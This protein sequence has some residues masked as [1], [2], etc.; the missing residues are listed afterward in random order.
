MLLEYIIAL[1]SILDR[2]EASGAAVVEY[3][4]S[5]VQEDSACEIITYP[6]QGEGST[7]MVKI[8]IPG[9]KGKSLGKSA[10]TIGLL[11]RLGGLGARPEV[12]GFV[13]D[14]DGALTVL[15]VA[16]KLLDMRR[17][18]DCLEGD[19][20]IST[21]I[22]PN[23]P[24][25]EHYPVHFMGSPVDMAQVNR[26]EVRSD[27]DA[28]LCVDTTKGN[29]IVN[30]KGFAITPTVKDGYILRVSESLLDL[31]EWTTGLPANV[32]PITTQDITPY[33]NG[34]YHVNSILQ[35]ATAT[36]APVV[37][38]A[39]TTQTVVPGC[40]PGASHA[41]DIETT[42]RFM[43]EAA[44]AFGQGNCPIYDPEEFSHLLRLYGSM[45]HLKTFGRQ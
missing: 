12:T 3:L 38:V 30:H 5:F 33:G 4:S 2:P 21:H 26:E 28:V 9:T 42:A 1:F 29:R 41:V 32:L 23:A 14:G 31:V 37:G 43:L 27:L 40:A 7:D 20:F 10:P 8:H 11:G 13:S 24:T 6:L 39:I 15:A 44:K 45:E 17:C 22:C 16:A 34:V 19:V 36:N 25:K 35:P 18:G